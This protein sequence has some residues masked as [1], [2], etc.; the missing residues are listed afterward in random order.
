MKQR[1]AQM[2]KAFNQFGRAVDHLAQSGVPAASH[3]KSPVYLGQYLRLHAAVDAQLERLRVLGDPNPLIVDWGAGI[4]HFSYVRQQ[5]GDR[6]E[7][8]TLRDPEAAPYSTS[9]E[10]LS[11]YSDLPTRPTDEP[12]RL[13]FEDGEVGIFV[14]CGVLEH[15]HEGGGSVQDSMEEIARVL[16]PGGAFVCAH[17]PRTKSWIE[18]SH[19]RSGGSH[20]DRLFRRD[21]VLRLH[22]GTDLEP[23]RELARY[24]VIPRNQIAQ[25]LQRKDRD[26]VSI[27]RGLHALD[28]VASKVAFPITQNYIF[29]MQKPL[30]AQTA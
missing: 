23:A 21:E 20:H 17:L 5:L 6:V 1:E 15:V 12:V 10:I 26:S 30:D 9:L 29:V 4:G 22:E 8:H 28:R 19:R 2:W 24:G 7:A 14:S 11:E 16:R 18:W 25:R 3:V 27:G 13:P